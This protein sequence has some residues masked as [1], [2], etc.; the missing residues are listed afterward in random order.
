MEEAEYTLYS[1][2]RFRNLVVY[3]VALPHVT[4][5]CSK[6]SGAE[7]QNVST[8][9]GRWSY[10]RSYVNQIHSICRKMFNDWVSF[11]M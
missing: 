1:F 4:P 8:L 10:R 6:I 11:G 9:F 7:L 2:F 3:T 5:S